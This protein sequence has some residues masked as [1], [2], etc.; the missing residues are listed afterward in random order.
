MS[1]FDNSFKKIEDEKYNYT[2]NFLPFLTTNMPLSLTLENNIAYGSIPA[3]AMAQ[4]GNIPMLYQLEEK[5]NSTGNIGDKEVFISD[6]FRG[7]VAETLWDEEYVDL[8]DN[9]IPRGDVLNCLSKFQ[10][11]RLI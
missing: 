4:A 9:L 5:E 11:V 8:W 3:V 7:M 1:N 2:N 10:W 6:V